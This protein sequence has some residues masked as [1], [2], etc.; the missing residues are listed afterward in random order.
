M[1]AKIAE[2]PRR[3]SPSEGGFDAL[4]IGVIDCANDGRPVVVR[5]EAP[6]QDFPAIFGYELTIVRLA[7]LYATRFAS[8]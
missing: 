2:L 8:V 7:Q 6:G 1:A 3:S 5:Y 4:A